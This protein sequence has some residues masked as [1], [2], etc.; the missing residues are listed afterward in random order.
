MKRYS[1]SAAAAID[2]VPAHPYRTG[3]KMATGMNFDVYF[4]EWPNRAA[5]LKTIE[6]QGRSAPHPTHWR[7]W[8]TS[9]YAIRAAKGE[10]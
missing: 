1:L 10:A 8:Q 9:R 2:H 6:I 3:Y 4:Q 5:L 7:D